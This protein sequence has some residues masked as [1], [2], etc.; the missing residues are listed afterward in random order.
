MGRLE[1]LVHQVDLVLRFLEAGEILSVLLLR[2]AEI[3]GKRV[4]LILLRLHLHF[5]G[6]ATGL[7]GGGQEQRRD[8]TESKNFRAIHLENLLAP[9]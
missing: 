1:L 9:A 7:G 8:T 4:D 3:L 5:G 6:M 2:L